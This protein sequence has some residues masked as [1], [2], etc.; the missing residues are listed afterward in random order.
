M[1]V[2]NVGAVAGR[3]GEN[4]RNGGPRT[5]R[6]LDA[7]LN[8]FAHRLGKPGELADVEV[9]PA[10]A[11]AVALIRD[12]HNLALDRA[13]VANQRTA[14]LDDDLGQAVAEMPGQRVG[15]GPRISLD[16]GD[17]AA[18]PGWK[19]AADIDHAQIDV[20]LGEQREHACHGANRT[21]PL[22]KVSLLRTDME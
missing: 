1:L 18:I 12:Q 3:A 6:R 11:A 20:G 8:A 10:L 7:V 2:E 22:R 9:H 17:L 16:A 5:S 15:N 21:V 13:C 19:S 4:D 14:R